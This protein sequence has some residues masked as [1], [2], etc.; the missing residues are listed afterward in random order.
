VVLL[1]PSLKKQISEK[2]E[3]LA[4][5]LNDSRLCHVCHDVDEAAPWFTDRHE[6]IDDFD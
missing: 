3:L 1:S 2:Q 4:H 5:V 6:Q